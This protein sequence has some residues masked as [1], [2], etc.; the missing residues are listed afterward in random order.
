MRLFLAIDVPISVRRSLARA[1]E[2]LRKQLRPP[3]SWVDPENFHLTL[4]FLGDVPDPKLGELLPVL[5][6]ITGNA[7]D[8]QLNRIAQLPPKGKARVVMADLATIP[9]ALQSLFQ[10]VEDELSNIGFQREPRAYHPHLTIAR[11]KVPRF[12]ARELSEIPFT[13]QAFQ[14]NDFRL[15]ESKLKP[16]GAE[17]HLAARFELA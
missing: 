6:A 16:S 5:Q 3:I 15:M 7:F 2:Y 8:L 10:S 12:I 13:P 1:Q 11:L 9:E 17:Y 14:V 4:K